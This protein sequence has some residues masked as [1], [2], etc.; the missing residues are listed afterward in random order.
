VRFSIIYSDCVAV[1]SLLC[2]WESNKTC[3][4]ILPYLRNFKLDTLPNS[5][6]SVRFTC[7]KFSAVKYHCFTAKDGRTTGA[8]TCLNKLSCGIIHILVHDYISNERYKW[9]ICL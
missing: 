5:L 1:S 7:K 9:W 2:F 8:V 6:Y 4:F 3:W